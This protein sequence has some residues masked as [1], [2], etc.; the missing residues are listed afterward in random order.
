[1]PYKSDDFYVTCPITGR[2]HY[3]SEMKM[4]WD[5]LLVHQSQWNP[6]QPQ[7]IIRVGVERE[8]KNTGLPDQIVPNDG[9]AYTPTPPYASNWADL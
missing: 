5:G 8:P 3:R 9:I 7:D 6:R 1:M 4:R 2:K